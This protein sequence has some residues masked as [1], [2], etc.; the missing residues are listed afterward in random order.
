MHVIITNISFHPF[1]IEVEKT[2][3]ISVF[4]EKSP[5]VNNMT[6]FDLNISYEET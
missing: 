4:L 2:S 1:K 6:A 3:F 5:K